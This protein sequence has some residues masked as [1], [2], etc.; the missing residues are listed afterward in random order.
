M[1]KVKSCGVLVMQDLPQTSFLLMVKPNRYDL[2]KGHLEP[3]EDELTCA[4]RELYEE[5]AIPAETIALDPTFRFHEVYQVKNYKRHG[6]Q[7]VEKTLI[8][9]LGWLQKTIQIKPCEHDDFIW[10][11]WNPPHQIQSRTI[12]PLLKQVE[13]HFAD[14][15]IQ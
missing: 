6:G 1:L 13:T 4:L 7:T 9:F 8:I 10:M 11:E 3:G 2:P 15:K 12:D 14:R 5:T